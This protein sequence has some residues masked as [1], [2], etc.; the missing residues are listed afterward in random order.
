MV[1][2]RWRIFLEWEISQNDEGMMLNT[3]QKKLACGEFV[4]G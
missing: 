1:F 2:S 4:T 3:S